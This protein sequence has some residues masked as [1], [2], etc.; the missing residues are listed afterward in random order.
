MTK[1]SDQAGLSYPL[2]V[3]LLLWYRYFVTTVFSSNIS[4]E[5]A[6]ANVYRKY[7][8]VYQESAHTCYVLL[9]DGTG[10]QVGPGLYTVAVQQGELFEAPKDYFGRISAIMSGGGGTAMIT[11]IS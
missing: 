2:T 4:T 8:A 5:V 7:F 6:K 10:T 1:L 9:E 3:T 11:E